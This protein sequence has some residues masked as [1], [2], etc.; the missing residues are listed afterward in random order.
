LQGLIDTELT[1]GLQLL[2]DDQILNGAGTNQSLTG[3]LNDAAINNVGQITAGTSAADLPA[4]MIDHI[5]AAITLCQQAEYYNING[6]VINPADWQVLETAKAT[7]GHY[8]LVAFAASSAETPSVWRVPV[9]VS[10]AIAADTFLLGDWTMGAKLYVRE[11]VSV[12][13][14]ESHADLFVQNGVAILA[15]ERMALGVNAPKAFATGSFVVAS[16][17]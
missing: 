8:L 11:G 5:R 1:Y 9:I 17:E 12:R 2:S 14:S 7:D 6:L 15:E 3:I 13:V 16:G 10:N 4:A